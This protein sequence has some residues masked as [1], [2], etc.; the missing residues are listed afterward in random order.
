MTAQIALLP[1][2]LRDRLK[3][4][5]AHVENF[6]QRWNVQELALFGSVIRDDFTNASDI[7][8]LIER[9][10]DAKRGGF[11]TVRMQEELSQLFERPVDLA[12]KKLLKNPFSRAEI[13]RT[14]RI[15]YPL[16]NA[17]FTGLI[18]ANRLL[19]ETVRNSASLFR[20]VEAMQAVKIFMPDKTLR[21]YL[22]DEMLQ[23]AVERNLEALSEAANRISASFQAQH[24][25]IDWS[26]IVGL[27]DVIDY[28]YRALNYKRVWNIATSDLPL[29]LEKVQ[30][31]V[32]DLPTENELT[33]D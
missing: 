3:T 19:T 27:K 12:Q 7:D 11:D 6:C 15:V 2:V 8:V 25:E 21:D 5:S 20:M 1:A 30:P 16:E 9:D 22:S 29:M 23:S 13:L 28:Q 18:S 14:Y 33:D 32:P 4:H 24:P 10:P 31:L 17:N 26:N